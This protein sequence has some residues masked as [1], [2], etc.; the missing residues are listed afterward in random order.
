MRKRAQK[1]FNWRPVNAS[2]GANLKVL[3][4]SYYILYL[5][6]RHLSDL[7]QPQQ[8]LGIQRTSDRFVLSPF[9]PQRKRLTGT[10]VDFTSFALNGAFQKLIIL[11]SVFLVSGQ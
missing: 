11:A 3:R 5:S 9:P 7:T 6:L 8:H 10:V 2:T 4:T 1:R